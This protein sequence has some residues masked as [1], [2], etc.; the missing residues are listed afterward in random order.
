[1]CGYV[2]PQG[3]TKWRVLSRAGQFDGVLCVCLSPSR[4]L[5]LSG[6]NDGTLRVWRVAQPSEE[7]TA[8]RRV[9]DKGVCALQAAAD[10]AE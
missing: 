10:V 9:A 6:A 1:M 3:F 8:T 2:Y 7:P 5:A 4:G